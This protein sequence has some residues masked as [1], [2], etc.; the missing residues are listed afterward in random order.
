M[1]AIEQEFKD[2]AYCDKD[3]GLVLDKG[4]V[5]SSRQFERKFNYGS[6][7]E[8]KEPKENK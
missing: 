6:I 2:G 4:A 1:K 8:I 5:I 7:I 3:N